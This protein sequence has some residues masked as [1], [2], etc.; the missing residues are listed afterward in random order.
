[1]AGKK[2]EGNVQQ[3][4]KAAREAREQGKA[5]SARNVTTG[6]SKQP[7]SAPKHQPH[8]HAERLGNI[9]RGKQ[10]DTSPEPKPG[11]GEPASKRRRED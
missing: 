4:R 9:H 6:A 11:Y 3:R 2:M 5:P 8:H 10:Q 7:H 1:M